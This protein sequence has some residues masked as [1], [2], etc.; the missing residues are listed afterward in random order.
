MQVNS[1]SVMGRRWLW[2]QPSTGNNTTKHRNSKTGSNARSLGL[3]RFGLHTSATS[4]VT[5]SVRTTSPPTHTTDT[6]EL[7]H[8]NTLDPASRVINTTHDS[9][10]RHELGHALL[11][12]LLGSTPD[13]INV[14]PDINNI[15]VV[16]VSWNTSDP[17]LPEKQLLSA[18]AGPTFDR[19][20]DLPTY[21]WL[22]DYYNALGCLESIEHQR[23]RKPVFDP[24]HL[25]QVKTY[26]DAANGARA[27]IKGEATPREAAF[28][29]MI[30]DL[31]QWPYVRHAR[32]TARRLLNIL[33]AAQT[34]TGQS[35]MTAMVED[36]RN[37]GSLQ[38][39]EAVRTFFETHLAS[40]STTD[41]DR[42]EKIAHH[43]LR[44]LKHLHRS[45]NVPAYY[46]TM[47]N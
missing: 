15:A 22:N 7:R 14:R 23:R 45:N 1:L 41:I 38:G 16:S 25:T 2:Q 18:M 44:M 33:E 4:S 13:T 21:P 35:V 27:I 31:N 9:T 40:S 19:S 17:K 46:A 43:G 8:N 10:V 29:A 30:D 32:A 12:V 11:D 26:L 47:P 36:L 3:A 39:R 37:K 42:L 28:L 5:S 24:K 20:D 6:V 34:E